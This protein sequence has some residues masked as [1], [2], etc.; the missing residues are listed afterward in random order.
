MPGLFR[1][2]SWGS[3][4]RTSV[5]SQFSSRPSRRPGWYDATHHR[6]ISGRV[7]G[8]AGGENCVALRATIV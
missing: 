2:V 8:N 1:R 3:P 4:N 7:A 5:L 6:V